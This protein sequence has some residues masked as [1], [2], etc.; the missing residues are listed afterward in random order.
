MET[1]LTTT[2]LTTRGLGVLTA[3]LIGG[4]AAPAGAQG[5]PRFESPEVQRGLEALKREP[6][7]QQTQ[8]RALEFFRIDAN[9]VGSMRSRASWKSVLPTVGMKVR[10]NTSDINLDKFDFN[11][12]P[13]QVAAR[14]NGT[15]RVFEM[16]AS[17]AWDLPRLVFN[18]ETL[19]VS[20]LVV[21]QEAILKEIT[22]LYYT[23]RR[24]QVDLILQPPTD[25][26]TKLSKELRIEELTS[27][28]DAMSGNLF[29]QSAIRRSR[30][31][32]RG[33]RGGHVEPVA[34]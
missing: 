24:L 26:A 34:Q 4:W 14:D 29:S 9:T 11:L 27:T 8:K 23:R 33:R 16:E 19:D 31:S 30:R 22:R 12:F 1:H 2:G 21:L 17:A 5:G 6:T 20:S 15:G 13:D 25:P 18:A 3:L 10:R 32:R 28:L 7:I